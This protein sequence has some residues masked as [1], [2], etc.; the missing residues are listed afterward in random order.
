[1]FAGPPPPPT[2]DEIRE[3]WKAARA[4]VVVFLTTI[5]VLRAGGTGALVPPG[6][7]TGA[8]HC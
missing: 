8:P 3:G 6:G 4:H 5:A 1:M 7:G 2:E